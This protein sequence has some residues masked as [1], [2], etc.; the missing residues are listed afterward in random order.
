MEYGKAF[1]VQGGNTYSLEGYLS[2]NHNN[3][4][5]LSFIPVPEQDREKVEKTLEL[6]EKHYLFPS[7]MENVLKDLEDGMRKMSGLLKMLAGSSYNEEQRELFKNHGLTL[8]ET[9]PKVVSHLGVIEYVFEVAGV[10]TPSPP[11]SINYETL[12]GVM[13]EVEKGDYSAAKQVGIVNSFFGIIGDAL[14]ISDFY[15]DTALPGILRK[16]LDVNGDMP[17]ERKQEIVESVISEAKRAIHRYLTSQD[18]A[19]MDFAYS[20]IPEGTPED[21]ARKM[22]KKK[23]LL[24]ERLQKEI[25]EKLK[26]IVWELMQKSPLKKVFQGLLKN[27]FDLRGVRQANES[28]AQ[29][30]R[31]RYKAKIR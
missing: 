24:E 20:P 15:V 12:D 6:L 1:I 3:I 18:I 2:L 13:K 21:K 28:V 25:P 11:V 14:G 26:L 9:K 29:K 27:I 22:R 4:D 17:E 10:E 23:R 7:L 8:P 31:H 16:V 19:D 5:R 30:K